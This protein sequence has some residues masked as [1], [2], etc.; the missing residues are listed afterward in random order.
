MPQRPTPDQLDDMIPHIAYEIAAIESSAERFASSDDRFI[1]EALLLHVRLLREFIWG[2]WEDQ[3]RYAE[4]SIY[5]EDYFPDP[6]VW[7]DRKGPL[8]ATLDETKHPI[9]KQL[10]HVCRERADP[11]FIQDLEQKAP[12]LRKEL[13]ENWERFLAALGPD[14]RASGF[15]R[16]HAEWRAKLKVGGAT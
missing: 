14:S 11:K 8:P 7:R 9:D 3:P 1:L 15:R 5:A 10:A 4:S 13:L 16:K 2:K 6:L 12:S